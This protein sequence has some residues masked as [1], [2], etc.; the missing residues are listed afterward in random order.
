[1]EV[2]LPGSDESIN[3]FEKSDPDN[4]KKAVDAFSVNMPPSEQR[5][6]SILKGYLLVEEVLNT[7]IEMEL[8]RSEF[9]HKAKLT[10]FQKIFIAKSVADYD[11]EEVWIWTAIEKLNSIRNKMTHRLNDPKLENKIIDFIK[12]VNI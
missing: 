2:I 12:Y 11:E 7:I 5:D 4:Y 6:L 9:I 1:M 10:F 3:I 8:R